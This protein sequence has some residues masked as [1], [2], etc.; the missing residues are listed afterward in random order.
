MTVAAH[1]ESTHAARPDPDWSESF[2]A[3]FFDPNGGWAGFTYIRRQPQ[4]DEYRGLVVV[5]FPD[6]SAGVVAHVETTPAE[7]GALRVGGLCHTMIEPLQLW[8]IQYQGE[9]FHFER[10]SEVTLGND[11]PYVHRP[12]RELELDL[13]IGAYH[14]PIE[15][16]LRRTRRALPRPRRN[17]P[18]WLQSLASLPL[19]VRRVIA[20]DDARRYEVAGP[21]HG[22]IVANGRCDE[23]AGSGRRDHA[24]GVRDYRVLDSWRWLNCNL[25]PR[26][27]FGL[28]HVEVLGLQ[29]THGHLLCDGRLIEVADWSLENDWDASGIG[30]QSLRIVATTVDGDEHVIRGEVLGSV[31][32]PMRAREFVSVV[33]EG[34]AR[35]H[36]NGRT[37]FG[38]SEFFERVHP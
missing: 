15:S 16:R 3:S 8:R 23:L 36:W 7:G 9:V 18:G 20:M 14:P 21:A 13:E 27:G 25:G 28:A 22:T 17:E 33:S 37:G 11:A 6:G 29:H 5:Y 32:L 34:R 19:R 2:Y 38:I 10:A 30:G 12:R 26:D 1:D 4:I 24:W 31:Q 35:F